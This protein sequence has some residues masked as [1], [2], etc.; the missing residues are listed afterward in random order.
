M[1]DMGI[2]GQKGTVPHLLLPGAARHIF[3][4]APLTLRASLRQRGRKSF[5]LAT[6]QL[7]LIPRSGTRRRGRATASRPAGR[8]WIEEVLYVFPSVL[9]AVGEVVAQ[10]HFH[11]PW[12]G[13]G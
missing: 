8:D 5:F 11:A 7:R 3:M 12:D 9:A 2:I 4:R 1:M 10:R 13:K 6:R